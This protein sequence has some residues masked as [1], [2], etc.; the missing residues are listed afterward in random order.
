[1][2]ANL[3]SKQFET[4][5]KNYVLSNKFSLKAISLCNQFE[6]LAAK[7]YG[8]FN[9]FAYFFHE[10]IIYTTNIFINKNAN[11]NSGK[12]SFP[13][14]TKDFIKNPTKLYFKKDNPLKLKS[15]LPYFLYFFCTK[16]KNCKKNVVIFGLDKYC[17]KI[18]KMSFKYKLNLHFLPQNPKIFLENQN[19]QLQFLEK[20]LLSNLN[21]IPQKARNVHVENFRKYCES[22]FERSKKILP[23]CNLLVGSLSYLPNRIHALNFKKNGA[24]IFSLAH[25]FG[26]FRAFDE[27]I[28]GYGELSF[29]DFYFDNGDFNGNNIKSH[30]TINKNK[31]KIIA[32]SYIKNKIRCKKILFRPRAIKNI[33]YIPTAFCENRR[34]G[35]YRDFDDLLYYNWQNELLSCLKELGF[36]NIS[37]KIHP[38]SLNS[39]FVKSL[40]KNLEIKSIK[41]NL[42]NIEYFLKQQDLIIFDYFGSGHSILSLLDKP[43]IY[44]DLGLRKMTSEFI[45]LFKER[46][47]WVNIRFNR[48]LKLQIISELS[49]I[50]ASNNDKSFSNRFAIKDCFSC[51]NKNG[52]LETAIK[53]IAA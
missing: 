29:S 53:T 47:F 9:I 51:N 27:P 40:I 1:M 45:K 37:Y 20:F 15:L 3:T 48:P 33:I 36:K 35:P 2:E 46:A 16:N 6:K 31:P 7:R 43:I 50:L 18:W 49:K 14:L 12:V 11:T 8:P 26:S 34:Y 41:T 52:V 25:G 10:I 38:N 39:V 24:T 19:A 32:S 44:F 5:Y 28:F 30:T 17:L 22:F 13:F 21:F 42:Q 23:P 4:I